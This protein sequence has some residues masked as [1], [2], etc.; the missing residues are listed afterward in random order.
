MECKKEDVSE[1]E[2]KQAV[3]Q[4][5]SYAVAE[6]ARYVWV[7][8]GIKDVY[9]E[10]PKKKPKDRLTIPDIPQYGVGSVA[11]Y[12]YAKGGGTSPDGQKLFELEVVEENDLTRRFKQAHP[13]A[14]GRR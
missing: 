5:F 9:Y 12:K 2:F 3:E 11:K 4:A 7:T 1:L 6:G 8:S 13:S 14:L 10:V